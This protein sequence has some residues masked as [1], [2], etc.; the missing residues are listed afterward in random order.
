M[1]GVAE[2]GVAL[3]VRGRDRNAAACH[4]GEEQRRRALH[5]EQHER[6]PRTART[7]A[8]EMRPVRGAGDQVV[9]VAH[10]LAAVAHAERERVAAREER[11]ELVARARIEAGSTSPSLRRRRARRRTRIRRTRRSPGSRASERRPAM[12][13]L[14][15]TSKASKPARSNAAAI[16]TW[17]LTPCSRRIAIRGPRA[18]RDERRRDVLGRLERQL[19]RASRARS[20]PAG[21]SYSSSA[22]SGVVAQPLHRV[23]RRRPGAVQVDARFVEQHAVHACGCGCG[24]P[25]RACR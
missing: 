25:A 14:M 3:A 16:S 23:R 18:G 21:A 15:C 12:R 24:R 1:R 2:L 19:R 5:L 6:A 7:V 17:P 4:A 11:R 22:A 10:H 20:R 9:Q 8:H 13:S